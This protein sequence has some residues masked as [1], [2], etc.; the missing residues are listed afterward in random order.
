MAAAA[1]LRW[2]RQ[3]GGSSSSAAVVAVGS[4]GSGISASNST[5]F[6]VHVGWER[7]KSSSSGNC[8]GA[9]NS[10][11]ANSLLSSSSGQD[12]IES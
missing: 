5:I 11:D 2:R 4:S 8:S 7:G 3:L 1:W 12:Y 9:G 6:C 10:V